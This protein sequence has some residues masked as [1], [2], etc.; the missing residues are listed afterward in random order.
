MHHLLLYV[1]FNS[2]KISCPARYCLKK[3]HLNFEMILLTDL[4]FKFTFV[5]GQ[6]VC[7]SFG[8]HLR[9]PVL[10]YVLINL[11]TSNLHKFIHEG[12]SSDWGDG[13]CV[14]GREI[15]S[16]LWIV[17]SCLNLVRLFMKKHFCEYKK[18]YEIE[19]WNNNK[20]PSWITNKLQICLQICGFRQII[21]LVWILRYYRHRWICFIFRPFFRNEYWWYIYRLN[22]KI[23]DKC[24]DFNFPIINLSFLCSNIDRHKHMH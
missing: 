11:K 19:F 21:G 16:K 5:F 4:Q 1:E 7:M 17:E 9:C 15:I 23:Y 14:R 6:W 13:Q 20:S 8:R 22:T 10:I 18:N 3:L 12:I 2:Y 24:D